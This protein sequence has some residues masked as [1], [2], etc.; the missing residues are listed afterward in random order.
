MQS[1]A[2]KI[3]L[4]K[5]AL[6]VTSI[7]NKFSP[8]PNI[9]YRSEVINFMCDLPLKLHEI[10]VFS[11][12]LSRE[13]NKFPSIKQLDSF[14]SWHIKKARKEKVEKVRSEYIDK[15]WNSDQAFGTPA[16]FEAIFKWIKAGAVHQKGFSYA[17]KSLKLSE[18][19]LWQCY[20]EWCEGRVHPYVKQVS[21]RIK[22]PIHFFGIRHD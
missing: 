4:E 3:R 10:E 9:E 2:D 21:L 8:K 7:S 6:L 13:F 15:P 17:I 18:D 19:L 16:Y 11:K 5:L 20:L 22:K 12:N 1:P 14:F